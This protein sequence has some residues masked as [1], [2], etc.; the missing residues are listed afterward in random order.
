VSRLSDQRGQTVFEMMAALVLVAILMV[1][2]V[3]LLVSGTRAGASANARIDA[4]QNTR[5]A[6]DRLEFEGRCSSKA[7]LVDSGAGVSFTLP[8]QCSHTSTSTVT[9]CV[10]GDVLTRLTSATCTGNGQSFISGVTSPT[11]FSL[12]TP[13]SG[14]LPQL[15]ISITVDTS[16]SQGTAATLDD[17]ITLRNGT[18]AS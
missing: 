5:L 16:N 14:D 13:A 4:Q 6:I 8:S 18:P 2:V 3:N 12:P 7:T 11:P 15:A 1:G 10:I 9:W 17:T